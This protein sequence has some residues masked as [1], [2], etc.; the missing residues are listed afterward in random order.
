MVLL[1]EPSWYVVR[2][3]QTVHNRPC[4]VVAAQNFEYKIANILDKPT[5]SLFGYI[6]VLVSV[7]FKSLNHKP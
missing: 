2:L 1:T 3:S 5:E 7:S 4:S 6:S